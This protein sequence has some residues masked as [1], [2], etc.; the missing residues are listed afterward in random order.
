MKI[1]R[2]SIQAWDI[3][4]ISICGRYNP[5][6]VRTQNVIKTNNLTQL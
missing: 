1:Y 3:E 2:F 6:H 4:G 5:K